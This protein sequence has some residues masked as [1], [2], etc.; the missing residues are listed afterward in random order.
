MIRPNL[1]GWSEEV[2]G[3]AGYRIGFIC[4]KHS[5]RMSAVKIFHG[6]GGFA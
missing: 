4:Q 6:P 2:M 5:E 3:T 1:S